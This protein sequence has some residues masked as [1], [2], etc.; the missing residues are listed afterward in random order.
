MKIVTS[1][2]NN[3]H[4]IFLQY[5]T[6]KKYIKT[7][8]E[9]IVFNDAKSFPDFSNDGDTSL[10]KKIHD[11]C[12]HLNVQCIDV[13]NE[14]QKPDEA[15]AIRC[16]NA[17]NTMLQYQKD[18][19][20][21][22]LQIDSDMFLINDYYFSKLD[23]YSCGVIFQS[24]TIDDKKIDYIWNALVYLDM[25]KISNINLMNWDLQNG[26]DVGGKMDEWIS[27]QKDIYQFST[28]CSHCWNINNAPEYIKKNIKLS[29][30]L[31]IEPRSVKN[32]FFCELFDEKFLH[33]RCGGNR[34]K[35]GN[36]FHKALSKQLMR[37]LI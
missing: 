34:L 22:Y 21:K 33:Y 5:E 14:Y 29:V 1:V 16:A 35:Q 37:I 8:Y 30:F 10:K 6:F 24:R 25:N 12:D 13:P 2:V 31:E 9:Y 17:C 26:T 18:N 19:P 15:S 4:F 36:G 27:K 3:P 7:D 11:I 32:K 23:K 28:L 20:D